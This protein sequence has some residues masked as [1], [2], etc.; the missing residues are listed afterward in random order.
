VGRPRYIFIGVILL[1]A[2]LTLPY[3]ALQRLWPLLLYSGALA[4]SL[5]GTVNRLHGPIS[6]LG[7][8]WFAPS[9]SRS[10]QERVVQFLDARRDR[11][12]FVGQ[13]WAPVIDLQY[14]SKGVVDF[15]GYTALTPEDLSRGVLVVTNSSFDVANDKEFSSLVASCGAPVLSAP[16][17]SIHECGGTKASTWQVATRL[18][19]TTT[20]P[21]DIKGE[22]F[23]AVDGCNLERV[24]GQAGST[25]PVSV[26]RGEL[27]RLS[28]WIVDEREHRVPPDPYV[29]LD[30]IDTRETWYV[31]FSP[32]LPR[33]DVARAKLHEAYRPSGFSVSI[34]TT[35][36]PP[37]EY[38]LQLLFRDSGPPS[39]CDNGRR[40]VVK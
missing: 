40:L 16:P 39:V 22:P 34:D 9:A 26:R 32:D 13:W 27:L 18:V 29:A 2:L 15:K 23:V 5:L 14:L 35:A 25:A 4:F 33:E 8:V 36:L 38:R 3:L 20:M 24:G 12:P 21:A 28:G 10:A 37:A 19:P 17:Y 1:S 7:G 6:D 11:R 31:S 30:S